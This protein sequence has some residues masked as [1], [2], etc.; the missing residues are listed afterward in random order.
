MSDLWGHN[1]QRLHPTIPKI[2]HHIWLGPRPIPDQ[3]AAS[4]QAVNP[5]WEQLIWRESDLEDLPMD[6][7]PSEVAGQYQRKLDDGCWHGAADIARLVILY[8]HGGFYVDIDSEP[9]RPLDEA[10][11][12]EASAVAAY[13]PVASIP[14]RIANGTMAA[15]PGAP[16]ISTAL[17]LLSQMPILDPPWDTTGGTLLTAAMLVHRR[18][19]DVRALPARTFYPTM[20]SGRK[21]PGREEPFCRHFWATTN[22]SYAAI[23][24]VLVPRRADGGPRDRIWALVKSWWESHGWEVVEGHHED[25]L[26]NAAKARNTAAQLAGQ[27]D[28]AIFA[29]ADTIPSSAEVIREAV[30][31]AHKRDV[32][33]RPFRRYYQLTEEATE[34]WLDTGI[35]PEGGAK[36]LGEQ[37]HGG[38]LVVPRKLYDKV[39]G[40]DERF[41]GWGWEDTAFEA[42]CRR[43]GG[44]RQLRGDVHH[45]W[46]PISTDR[47]PGSPQY[48]ANVALGQRYMKAGKRQMERILMERTG[49]V[50][51]GRPTFAVMLVTN[52]RRGLI[53]QTVEALGLASPIDQWLVCDDSGEPTME[54]WLQRLLPD[55]RID[56]HQHLGHG[57]AI[58]KAWKMAAEAPADWI[59]WMEEDMVLE[60]E[61]D[62]E[63][64]AQLTERHKLAQM[65]LKRNA[66]FPAEVEAGPSQI[67]RFD[68]ESFTDVEEEDGTQWLCHRL[69]YS[70]NPHLVSTDFIRTHKWPARP[71]SEHHFSIRLFRDHRVRVGLW[72]SRS[73]PPIVRHA[74][75]ERTG[76]GY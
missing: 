42:A 1:D 35:R 34:Q 69:F 32:Y 56:A 31:V 53:E 41:V 39:H 76:D 74:G 43:M 28:V 68:P 55:A 17:Q 67:D 16:V 48:K 7:I 27:W 45:L 60:Q 3:W 36:L 8:Q 70:L 75:T 26:F 18:C 72:G 4:W 37:A 63:A 12:L 30:E 9:L 15:K 51:S 38:V 57:P 54:G 49:E 58:A 73:S 21:T 29:D 61:L 25:G 47:D 52:G 6:G 2:I 71:N 14:G 33:V 5:G 46:H 59:L 11:W 65:V 13:E 40:Y 22:G 64:M 50:A 23:S 19:C 44:F 66:H 20:A 10:D 62:L 24:K